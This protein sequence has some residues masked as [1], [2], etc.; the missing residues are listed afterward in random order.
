MNK[1]DETL[2]KFETTE[3]NITIKLYNETPK[4][5]DNFIKLVKTVRMTALYSIA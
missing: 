4:H 5:R 1:G 2:V 3:G